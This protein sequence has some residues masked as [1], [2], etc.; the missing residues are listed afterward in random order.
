MHKLAKNIYFTNFKTSQLNTEPFYKYSEQH[1]SEIYHSIPNINLYLEFILSRTN[2]KIY[3]IDNNL[4][5]LSHLIMK[6]LNKLHS[7]IV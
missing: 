3:F 5:Y 2:V 7:N 6:L 1:K 4:I